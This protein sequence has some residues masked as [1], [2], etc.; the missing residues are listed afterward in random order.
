MII[1]MKANSSQADAQELLEL[2]E[3]RGL[4]PLYMPGA[5]RTVLGALGD[6]RI[7]AELHLENHP[8]VDEVK[9]ILSPYK[10]VSRELHPEDTNVQVAAS[11]FSADN[12]VVIAGPCAVESPEQIQ[13]AASGLKA[14]GAHLLRGGLFKPRTS[15]YSFQGLGIDGLDCFT[16]AAAEQGM[17]TVTEVTDV[18]E[19][20]QLD[21]KVSMLQ[22]GARNMQNYRLLRAV[23][24]TKTPVLLKRGMSAKVDELLLAAEY[25]VDNGNDQV[26]LCERGIRT[27]ETV[28]RNTLDLNA[29]AYMKQRTHLPVVVDPSHGTGVRELVIPMSK[30]AVAAGADGLIVEVHPDP[31]SASSD[32][33]QQLTIKQFEQLMR[34]IEPFVKASGRELR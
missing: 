31:A 6:E 24:K 15:P 18:A 21:G 25:I 16:Q 22:I 10:K 33:H 11:R 7:L 4:Q 34:Q 2:I 12:F 29:V 30:A 14:A 19:V 9:P 28:T 32:A 26:V 20:A 8:L 1:V 5:E 13:L 23:G 17:G 27:Y 3:G